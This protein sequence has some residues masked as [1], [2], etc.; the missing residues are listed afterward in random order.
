MLLKCC[1]SVG[2]YSKKYACGKWSKLIPEGN[3]CT[4]KLNSS[5]K[6]N[7]KWNLLV[8]GTSKL[9]TFLESDILYLCLYPLVSSFG[10][11][12]S[13]LLMSKKTIGTKGNRLN[14]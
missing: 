5:S 12:L 7:E 3:S 6:W 9:E 13:V 14:P 8:A 1:K 10:T 2:R 4:S 11:F